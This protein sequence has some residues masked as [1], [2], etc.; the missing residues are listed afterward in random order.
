MTLFKMQK[1][2]YWA[3]VAPVRNKQ[4]E[5]VKAVEDMTDAE[6]L[7]DCIETIKRLVTRYCNTEYHGHSCLWCPLRA[8]KGECSMHRSLYSL[9]RFKQ[10][11]EKI[12]KRE[13]EDGTN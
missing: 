13:K 6:R 5:P 2:A 11:L 9:G 3:R 1:V 10:A 12:E 8:S 7:A 4:P